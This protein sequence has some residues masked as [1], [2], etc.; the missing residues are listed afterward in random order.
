[1]S[2]ELAEKLARR[3]Q[4][5]ADKSGEKGL[6]GLNKNYRSIYAGK[7]TLQ[8]NILNSSFKNLKNFR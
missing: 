8:S 5:N 4:I 3:C 2:N 1:M 6:A 7:E